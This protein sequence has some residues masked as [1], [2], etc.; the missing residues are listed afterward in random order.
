M[1]QVDLKPIKEHTE[2]F[3]L[4]EEEIKRLFRKEIYLP[5]LREA[6]IPKNLLKNSIQDLVDAIKSG[7]IFFSRGNFKGQFSALTSKEIKKLG[8]TWDRKTSSWKIGSNAL[9]ADIKIAVSS[10]EDKFNRTVDRMKQ[11]LQEMVPAEIADKLKASKIFDSTLWKTNE[12]FKKSLRGISIPPELTDAR[13]IRIAEEYTNNLKLYIK[14]WT[15][16][17]IVTLRKQIEDRSFQGLRREG[18]T[19]IIQK[20][21]G[22]SESKAKFLAHQETSLL[23]TKFKQSRYE[24][25]GVNQ[26]KWGCVVGSASHPVRP[27]HKALQGKIFSWSNPPVTDPQGHKNNPGQDYNCRCFAIPIAKF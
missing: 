17:E 3:D 24:D 22:V 12:E 19:K 25:A 13:R 26:Y 20:S 10:S 11:K 9:P 15:E 14:D 5:L 8:A 6:E 2:D 4:L 27:M 1:K 7:K 23:M 16:K 21:Y 18:L